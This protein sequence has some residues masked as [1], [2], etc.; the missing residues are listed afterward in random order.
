MSHHNFIG[1]RNTKEATAEDNEKGA[2]GSGYSMVFVARD[3]S[4]LNTDALAMEEHGNEMKVTKRGRKID[5]GV[6][7]GRRHRPTSP[8]LNRSSS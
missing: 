8:P 1:D 5:E 6:E 2:E 7:E 4:K 3:L